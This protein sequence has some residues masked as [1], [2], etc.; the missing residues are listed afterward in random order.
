MGVVGWGCDSSYFNSPVYAMALVVVWRI[1]PQMLSTQRE[2]FGMKTAEQIN[3]PQMG[4]TR[5]RKINEGIPIGRGPHKI[6]TPEEIK[7]HSEAAM[8]YAEAD[9]LIQAVTNL[10]ADKLAEMIAEIRLSAFKSGMT[11]VLDIIDLD[12]IDRAAIL[13]AR[14][15]LK[16][17]DLK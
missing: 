16:P 14:D 13:A 12:E 11:R 6:P 4:E 3:A 1:H 2:V 15:N 7:I 5:F 17:E 9:D 8:R 10:D